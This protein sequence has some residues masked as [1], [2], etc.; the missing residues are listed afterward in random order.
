MNLSPYLYL[1]L[2]VQLTAVSWRDINDR[3]ISNAWGGINILAFIGLAI[4]QPNSYPFIL[5]SFYYP[6]ACFALG[7][8]LFYWKLMGAGDSKFLASFFLLIPA[9]YHQQFL[10][11]L[12]WSSVGVSASWILY[13]SAYHLRQLVFI[14]QVKDYSQLRHIYSKKIAFAPVILLAWLIFGHTVKI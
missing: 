12:L 7:W 4:W 1:Y 11:T 14:V 5:S 9:Q 10:L 13:R 8:G 2:L 3:K 6:L